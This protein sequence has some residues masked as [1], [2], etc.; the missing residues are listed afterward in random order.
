MASI[1]SLL[2]FL[3]TRKSVWKIVMYDAL[4]FVKSHGFIYAETYKFLRPITSPLALFLE[5]FYFRDFLDA[6]MEF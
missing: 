4:K 5:R 6:V 1:K 3:I 2:Q